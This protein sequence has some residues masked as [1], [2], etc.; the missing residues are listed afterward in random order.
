MLLIILKYKLRQFYNALTRASLQKKLEWLLPLVIIPYYVMLIRA[1]STVYTRAYIESGAQAAM[2]LAA[3]NMSIV[4]FFVLIST[5]ALTLYRLFQSSDLTLLMSLPAQDKSIFAAKLLE[6]LGDTARNMILPSPILIAYGSLVIRKGNLICAIVFFA[7]WIAILLQVSGLSLIVAVLFGR[8]TV[9][10]KWAVLSRIIA[11]FSALMLLLIFMGYIQGVD[12]IQAAKGRTLGSLSIFFP[13]TWL[14]NLTFAEYPVSVRLTYAMSFAFTTLALPGIA[15]LLFKTRFRQ[16]WMEITETKRRKSQHSASSSIGITGKTLAVIINEIR[17]IGREPYALV[18]LFVPVIL[19][20]IFMLFRE[21]DPNT[22]TFYVSF[23]S[24]ISTASYTLSCIGREGRSFAML[25]NLPVNISVIL[26]AK[27]II[28]I[29]LSLAVTMAFILLLSLFQ[30]SALNHIPYNVLIGIIA[31]TYFPTCGMAL[32]AIFPKFDFTNPMK[33]ISMPGVLAFYFMSIMFA[34]TLT[35][36][37][38]IA[39]YFIPL[40]LLVWEAI[41]LVL[42]KIGK[43]RLEKMDV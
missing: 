25:R 12:Y 20:P 19:F 43:R 16:T 4:F 5:A 40:I 11:I 29:I 32:A 23:I 9:R 31:S 2:K 13:S 39:R 33:A 28:S 26:R 3:S 35:F 36:M 37:S 38:S 14:L 24:M 17:I 6:S 22:Q 30:K 15:F 42:L 7:G 18:G 34:I 8:I 41:A 1:M 10:G 27:M 21:Q